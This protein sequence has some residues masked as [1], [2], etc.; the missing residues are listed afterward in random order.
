MDNIEEFTNDL[1][2]SPKNCNINI[3]FPNLQNFYI[4]I[5]R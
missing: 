2:D 5:F 4:P 3:L 1:N